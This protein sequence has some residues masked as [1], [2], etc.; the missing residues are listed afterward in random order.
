MVTELLFSC[1]V[2]VGLTKPNW[3]AEVSR[4]MMV[5]TAL[6]W[7]EST[8]PLPTVRLV[9]LKSERFTVRLPLVSEL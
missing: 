6:V 5:R 1:T 4:S 9:A 2:K 7:P 3:P 8:T